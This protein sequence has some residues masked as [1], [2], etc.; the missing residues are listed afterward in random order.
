MN[1]I[2]G[3]KKRERVNWLQVWKISEN[4]LKK[5]NNNLRNNRKARISVKNETFNHC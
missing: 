1:K 2:E 3:M 4:D 5:N